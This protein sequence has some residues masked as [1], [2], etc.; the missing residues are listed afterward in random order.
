MR[1]KRRTAAP[2]SSSSAAAEAVAQPRRPAAHDMGAESGVDRTARKEAVQQMSR[3]E[4]WTAALRAAGG[5]IAGLEKLHRDGQSVPAR[6][7]LVRLQGCG[8]VNAALCDGT[9]PSCLMGAP[10]LKPWVQPFFEALA[11]HFG[12]HIDQLEKVDGAGTSVPGRQV[13]AQEWPGR[14]LTRCVLTR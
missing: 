11:C 13:G 10:H 9:S 5:A 12:L 3:Q 7:Y 1:A 6:H 2:A 8:E 14:V 4:A